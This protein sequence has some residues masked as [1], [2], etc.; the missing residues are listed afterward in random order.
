[1][2][3]AMRAPEA[4]PEDIERGIAAAEAFF[5]EK[6][7]TAQMACWADGAREWNDIMGFPKNDP[8]Y[9]AMD[10]ELAFIWDEA[11]GRALA[12]CYGDR[13][14]PSYYDEGPLYLLDADGN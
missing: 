6:D 12:A 1:M 13:P 11:V 10:R 3:L 5:R 2:K 4:S 8:N 9:G 14:I 7:V